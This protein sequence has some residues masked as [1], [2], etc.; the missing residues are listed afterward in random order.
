M[1]EL[2][3]PPMLRFLPRFLEG[4]TVNFEIAMIALC[5]GLILGVLLAAGRLAGGILGGATAGATGLMR[6]A[7]TF[8]V[9]FFVLNAL[10]HG[11]L[12][13]MMIVALSLV[14]YSAAYIS[15]SGVDAMRQYRLGSPL[16]SFLFFPN[17]ARAFFVLVMSSGAGAAI[18][19][20]EGI[21]ALLTHAEHLPSLG[22]KLGC[23]AIGVAC[24]AIPLQA[25]FAVIGLIQRRLGRMA[26][27]YSFGT[28]APGD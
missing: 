8:V 25:G 10:P 3:S 11:D 22:D 21:T 1:S 28:A 24:F 13:G 26:V 27:G 7:P 5:L 19:V 15:D 17:V 20:R 18:G 16:A 12:S 2:L 6:A 4:M 14:P 9:M 23:F